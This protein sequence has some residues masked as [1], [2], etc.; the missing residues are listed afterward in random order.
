MLGCMGKYWAEVHKET[1]KQ[2]TKAA[3]L[4]TRDKAIMLIV[5]QGIICLAIYFATSALDPVPRV[6]TALL[7]FLFVPIWYLI[8][9]PGVPP[10][11]ATDAEN[12]SADAYQ[13]LIAQRDSAIAEAAVLR[14]EIGQLKKPP[15]PPARDLMAIYQLGAKVAV[16]QGAVQPQLSASRIMFQRV[17]F[18][19][20]FNLDAPFEY[21][22]FVLQ[23]VQAPVQIGGVRYG[24]DNAMPI[25][26]RIIGRREA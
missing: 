15:L 2:A 11:L 24:G 17:A 21:G 19:D 1:W 10:K 26:A 7:P 3:G 25:V 16:I 4:E 20:Q 13:I 12:L 18:G 23:I 5:V 22:E 6:A 8:K 9:L 14:A